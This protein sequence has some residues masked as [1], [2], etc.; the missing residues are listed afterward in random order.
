MAIFGGSY[1]D[2]MLVGGS[3][4][5]I[6]WGGMGDDTLRGGAGD[7]RLRGGPGA[8]VI[9]GG[10]GMDIADYADSMA[11]I[12][13]DLSSAFILDEDLKPRI[14]GGDAEG[15]TLTSV[16]V[17]WVRPSL[18]AWSAAT[19]W[20]TF[21]ATPAT[22]KSWAGM[23]TTCCAVATTATSCR[24]MPADDTL[25]GDADDDTV[26]G[27][28]GDD[29]LFGGEHD[30]TLYGQDGDDVLE[31]GPGADMLYGGPNSDKALGGDTASYTMSPEGVVIRLNVPYFYANPDL[32]DP[33][34]V[35]AAGG[36]ATGDD[37]DGIENVRGSMY[38]DI[39][40]GGASADGNMGG[41]IVW[42]NAGDDRIIGLAHSTASNSA[43][44]FFGGKGDDTLQGGSAND[45]LYGQIG[46]D[47]LEG[48]DDDDTLFGGPGADEL[49]GGRRHTS[50]ASEDADGALGDTADYSK[51]PEAV[52]VDLSAL[53]ATGEMMPTAMGGYAEGDMLYGI[54]NITG[55]D[56]TDLLVGDAEDNHLKGGQGDDWDD[57]D[58]PR[59]TEGGLFGGGGNDTLN[60]GRGNDW[61]DASESTEAES[62]TLIGSSGNDMLIG[63]AGNDGTAAVAAVMDDPETED[64][65]E[66]MPGM[67][68]VAGLAG[69]NGDDTLAGG[70]GADIMDGGNGSDT[71]DYSDSDDGVQ[72]SFDSTMMFSNVN[73]SMADADTAAVNKT[74]AYGGDASMGMATTG[75]ADTDDFMADMLTSLE[76]VTGSE[77]GQNVLIGDSRYNMLKGGDGDGDMAVGVAVTRNGAGLTITN[78]DTDGNGMPTGTEAENFD[79]VLIG[80]AGNDV[81]EGG[82]GGDWFIGGAGADTFVVGRQDD[83][84][85][86]FIGDFSRTEGDKIDLTDLNLSDN[87][88]RAILRDAGSPNAETNILTLDLNGEN[89]GTLSVEIADVFTSL[90]LDDFIL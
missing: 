87:E 5:D 57:P 9:N 15:D 62:V 75:G 61:L 84:H 65:D 42:A 69:G 1:M 20:T 88:L 27:G 23:A 32:D 74:A 16:E 3:D 44:T 64:M 66:S 22:T 38:D 79:D 14:F 85:N 12:N 89:G 39:I 36:D 83:D 45:K 10:P 21:S 59:V 81:L 90:V 17:I 11:G 70:A 34:Q 4:A 13:I 82:E 71:A 33:E 86:D 53:S 28:P 7:D 72:I 18:T 19:A 46:D 41:N 67:S 73:G 47:R 58:T 50:G 63:G 31:G 78:P 52:M 49:F 40:V 8:D 77:S 56:Y 24:A 29:M 30:D 6:L 2:D 76:H 35:L 51:S 48:G 43:D 68:A 25:Y 80:N 26:E 60:G 37:Y 54:E 55:T